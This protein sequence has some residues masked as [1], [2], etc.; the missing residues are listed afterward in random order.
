[1]SPKTNSDHHK[2]EIWKVTKFTLNQRK[3]KPLMCYI[4]NTNKKVASYEI[5]SW[6]TLL[7][8]WWLVSWVRYLYIL[9]WAQSQYDWES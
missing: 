5:R 6:A 3:K 7:A 2:S 4:Q 9:G 1:M 8:T